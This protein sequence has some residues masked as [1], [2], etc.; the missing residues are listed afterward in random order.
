MALI[1]ARF[2]DRTSLKRHSGSKS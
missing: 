1:D 2:L